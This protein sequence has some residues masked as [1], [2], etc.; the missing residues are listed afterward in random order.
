M[1]A[2]QGRLST[3][4]TGVDVIVDA[5]GHLQVDVLSGTVTASGAVTVAQDS[6]GNADAILT[7]ANKRADVTVTG[8][9][10]AS[11]NAIASGGALATTLAATGSRIISTADL[12]IG[13][14]GVAVPA[15][16]TLIYMDVPALDSSGNTTTAPGW[17]HSVDGSGNAVWVNFALEDLINSTPMPLTSYAGST[18]WGFQH[19]YM[20]ANSKVRVTTTVA[21]TAT[22]FVA[23]LR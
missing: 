22:I 8:L 5:A 20:N 17:S 4:G 23:F 7:D 18:R 14:A 6:S 16:T 12:T 10:D 21:Q 11:G 9:K 13:T 1:G 3:G 19:C 15:G 2:I